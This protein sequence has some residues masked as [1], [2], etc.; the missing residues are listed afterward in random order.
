MFIPCVRILK[1]EIEVLCFKD[2]SKFVATLK[3]SLHKRLLHYEEQDGSQTEA[4]LDPR[5]KPPWCCQTEMPRYKYSLIHV[6]RYTDGIIWYINYTQ[7]VY[8]LSIPHYT[9]LYHNIPTLYL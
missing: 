5:F 9:T 1:A 3:D 8:S 6:T 4:S 7:F 2:A